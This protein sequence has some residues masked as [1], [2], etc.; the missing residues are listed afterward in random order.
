LVRGLENAHQTFRGATRGGAPP[1]SPEVTSPHRSSALLTVR[2]VAERL[3]VSTGWVYR[4]T[5]SGRLGH[6]RFAGAGIRVPVEAVDAY[7]RS[8][9]GL[10]QVTPPARP[11]ADQG[12]SNA[13]RPRSVRG[14]R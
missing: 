6:Q 12:G 13:K 10:G 2:E 9:P 1:E 11:Q 3:R 8:F 7:L 4:E 5:G 14:A